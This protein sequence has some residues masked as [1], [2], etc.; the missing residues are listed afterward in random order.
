MLRFPELELRPLK[1][2]SVRELLEH[3]FGL[4]QTSED[5]RLS[6]GE[7]EMACILLRDIPS[8]HNVP[9]LSCLVEYYLEENHR[10]YRT[11]SAWYYIARSVAAKIQRN[12]GSCL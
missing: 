3:L 1:L 8:K 5:R 4:E 7:D 11:L 10:E 2:E 6:W 12:D 9:H